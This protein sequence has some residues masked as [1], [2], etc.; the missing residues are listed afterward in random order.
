[1]TDKQLAQLRASDHKNLQLTCSDG[2]IIEAEILFMDEE[3]RD[4]VCDLL[5][6]TKPEKYKEARGI[7]IA[8][9]WDDITDLQEISK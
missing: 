8:I 6:T 4:V 3:Y 2:E 1:V 5:S 7:C 9:K